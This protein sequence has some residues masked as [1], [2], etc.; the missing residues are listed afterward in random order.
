VAGR[1]LRLA[2]WLALGL[3]CGG[4]FLFYDSRWGEAEASQ[5]RVA[6]KR[7]P[8][9]LRGE[10]EVVEPG[11]TAR[12]PAVRLKIRAYATPHY[13]GALVDGKAQF[14]QAIIDANPTFDHDLSIRLELAG[15][16]VWSKAVADDDLAQLIEQ[17]M[18]EDPARDVDWVVVLASPR[19]MV[20]T[21]ADQLGVGLLLGR[22]L[23]IRA[24]SDAAEF[25]A[26]E[27]G[28]DELSDG[29]RRRLYAA[30]KRHKAATVLLHEIGH[31]L[32]MPHEIDSRSLMS[33][34]Y[35]SDA[36][37][38]GAHA[39]RLGRRALELRATEPGTELHR[40]AAQGALN[41]LGNAPEHTWEPG[42]TRD[43]EDLLKRHLQGT[44]VKLSG[45]PPP[46]LT[47][48]PAPTSAPGGGAKLS[49]ADRALFTRAREAQAAG[50]IA[51]ARA[52]AAPLFQSYPDEF[53]V[54]ELRCQ[55]AMKA[56]LSA[57]AETAECAPLVRLSRSGSF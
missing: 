57:D 36:G 43:V 2:S 26:I 35:S 39:A 47:P 25:D 3:L 44:Q 51:E 24:M 22:H 50:N 18:S 13:A 49:P 16:S 11:A 38:F 12:A 21:S 28:F 52:I 4:C 23:A 7:M 17:I 46:R 9:Q 37:A 45:K 56:G 55:L 10:G 40:K 53:A 8:S 31:T 1:A 15:Y 14:E 19:Q 34:K 30:R 20:A 5:K 29:E 32:G 27:R 48:A 54:Q 42:A 6:A 33:A 41:V